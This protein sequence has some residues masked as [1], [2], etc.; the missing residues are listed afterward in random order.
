M[1]T[2]SMGKTFMPVVPLGG[3]V[4]NAYVS[5]YNTILTTL[6][7]A[8]LTAFTDAGITWVRVVLSKKL[9]T[10]SQAQ[11]GRLSPRTGFQKG[12]RA[13]TGVN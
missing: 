5:G 7:T 4:N 13:P 6:I 10:A 1:G 11:S 8:V 12:R 2:K 9:G 3:I